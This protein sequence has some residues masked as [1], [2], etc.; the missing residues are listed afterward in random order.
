[1]SQVQQ[2]SS[3][4]THSRF[5]P[6]PFD[7]TSFWRTFAHGVVNVAGV[8]L[9]YVEG[10]SG[11]PIL[12]IPGWP[13][14]WYAWRHVMPALVA[15]GRRVIA[16]DPRGMGDSD[17]PAG[18]YDMATV[19]ADIHRLVEALGL[20]ANGPIDVA[21][22]DIGSWIGYAYAADWPDDV[23]RMALYDAA[24]PGIT[25]PPPPAGIPS[26]AANAKIW[27]FSFNRLDDLPEILVQGHERAYLAWLFHGKTVNPWAITPEDLDE[28]ERVF[29]LAGA[30]R[31]AF[32]YYREIFSEA[33]LAGNRE[34]AQYTLHMP[35][36]AY[37]ADRG[38]GS[39][40][41]DTLTPIAAHLSGGIVSDCG[42]YIPEEAPA[43]VA[44]QLV[45]FFD[46]SK[47]Q[48]TV[49]RN[50]RTGS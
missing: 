46:D 2:Q 25:P 7:P 47:D 33:G 17:K 42:H 21:G 30:A 38:V 50:V 10:G 4:K 39:M 34:R 37:G 45:S 11:A 28:Y 20:N 15:A 13:Q 9:H 31:A 32:S 26:A 41:A 22:H 12:L 16:L 36:L 29:K 24:L 48:E 44:D 40:L 43:T 35:I 6:R 27:H 19:A 8:R 23:R 14:S 3:E 18:G 1:M 49:D 5:A